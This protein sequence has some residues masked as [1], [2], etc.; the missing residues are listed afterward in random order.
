MET[1][2]VVIFGAG[3]GG[4]KIKRMLISMGYR[5]VA[6][7]DNSEKKWGTIVDGLPIVPPHTLSEKNY[8]ILV[9]SAW[10]KEIIAQLAGVGLKERIVT[11]DHFTFDYLQRSADRYADLAGAK[12]QNAKV[13]YVFALDYAM[14]DGGVES[15][16]YVIA[17]ELLKMGERV[18]FISDI[19]PEI[20]PERFADMVS[21]FDIAGEAYVETLD[22]MIDHLIA[23]SPCVVIDSW[24]TM[25]ML[26]C[27]IIKRYGPVETGKN[28]IIPCLIGIIHNS[29]PRLY[30]TV[31]A[32][33]GSYDY[34]CAVGREL[35]EHLVRDYAFPREKICYR[36]SPI[37]MRED[38][39]SEA[40]AYST[41]PAAPIRIGYGAR[42]V[43][44]QKRA[45]LL[46]PLIDGLVK[47]NVKFRLQI[48]GAGPLQETIRDYVRERR[49]E[50]SVEIKGLIPR[51]EMEAFWESQ[52][53]FIN[54]SDY[55]G[56]SLSM[57]ESMAAGCVPVVTD[58]TGVREFITE[59]TGFICNLASP[60]E[61]VEKLS[62]L[63]ADREMMAQTGRNAAEYVRARCCPK[64]Y[65]KHIVSLYK[66]C[67][68]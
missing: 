14:A 24:Q 32:F 48:A 46:I 42:L 61:F 63:S 65:A 68:E 22:R 51:D 67:E 53:V 3:F 59:N 45:D 6:F 41:D 13:T 43:K 10:E 17:D 21:T 27:A 11:R 47:N 58:V 26:A 66:K 15:W 60:D 25:T 40:R 1:N 50:D 20:V 19:N 5:V 62:A 52:D 55:E 7:C 31:S 2:E 54:L 64:D 44:S 9:A 12:A 4:V 8:S 39:S 57:L 30:E 18:H 36:P 56:T 34:A 16:S 37:I 29:L 33:A 28:T 23:L 38:F 49:L 35:S